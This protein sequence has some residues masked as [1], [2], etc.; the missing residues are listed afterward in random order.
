MSV[1]AREPSQSEAIEALAG[2]IQEKCETCT[3]PK[4]KEFKVSEFGGLEALPCRCEHTETL[5]VFIESLKA[6]QAAE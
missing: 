6:Q 4:R 3:D 5:F 2:A 1:A